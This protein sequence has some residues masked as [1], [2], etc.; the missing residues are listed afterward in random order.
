MPRS[1]AGAAPRTTLGKIYYYYC[2]FPRD[3]F[4]KYTQNS[5]GTRSAATKKGASLEHLPILQRAGRHGPHPIAIFT[6]VGAASSSYSSI[7]AIRATRP[8]SP[9]RVCDLSQTFN[10]PN[11]HPPAWS[12][13]LASVPSSPSVLGPSE[14]RPSG[15]VVHYRR[16]ID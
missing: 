8:P 5:T 15:L 4:W 16:Q 1:N 12:T 13:N 7:T 6:R 9:T 11:V 14:L 3:F 2:G 10:L